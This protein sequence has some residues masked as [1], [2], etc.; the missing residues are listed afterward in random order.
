MKT[1]LSLVLA[2]RNPGKI[3]EFERL[4]RSLDP[5]TEWRFVGLTDFQ[6]PDVQETGET[7]AENARQKAVHAAA[8][9]GLVCLGEDSGLEVDYLGGQPGV[10]SHRFSSSGD[11]RDNNELL[12]QRL[13]G[14]PRELR[15]ARYR[16]AISVASPGEV[17]VSGL[18]TVE[19]LIAEEYRGENGFGY[20]PLFFSLELGKTLGEASDLEK[21]SVSHR[22]KALEAILPGLKSRLLQMDSGS[23]E[24]GC[25]C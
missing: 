10:K 8:H 9:T 21:D 19:G 2:T 18:G 3:R 15:T 16:C 7:F 23:K 5:E 14:V 1:A 17:L 20:D 12:L 4:F 24:E 6:V 25:P 11:D 13:Q 22:R